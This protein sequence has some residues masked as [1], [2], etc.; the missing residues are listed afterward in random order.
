MGL[1]VD[2]TPGS[3][4]VTYAFEDDHGNQTEL[5]NG[6]GS[7]IA[8]AFTS[9][10]ETLATVGTAV[11][12]TTSA[13]NPA[14][15]APITVVTTVPADPGPTFSGAATNVDGSAITTS[16]GA[17]W[18]DPAPS[19]PIPVAAGEP[20]EGVLSVADTAAV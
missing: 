5:P 1:T 7:G 13:G 18:E 10:D 3:E 6:D 11:A 17:A 16:S 20:V 12:S 4:S 9:S 19:D 8:V 14:F 2:T 15:T